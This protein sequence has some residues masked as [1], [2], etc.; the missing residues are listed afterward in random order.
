MKRHSRTIANTL[1]LGD[2]K[3]AVSVSLFTRLTSRIL[4]L[5]HQE[6]RTFSAR[7]GS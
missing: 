5:D 6:A 3:I 2:H 4:A 1:H 7:L